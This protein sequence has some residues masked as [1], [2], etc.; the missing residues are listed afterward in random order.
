MRP[1]YAHATASSR[2]VIR[3]FAIY[4]LN[5]T[6]KARS[7][8]TCNTAE[9]R[10]GDALGIAHRCLSKK[11]RDGI[12]GSCEEAPP[13]IDSASA[14]MQWKRNHY[15]KIEEKFQQQP[16]SDAA[17]PSFPA[18]PTDGDNPLPIER[19]EDV[20]L[21][22]K[23]MESRVTKRKSRTLDELAQKGIVSGRRNVRRSD[24]DLWLAAG[25]YDEDK[26]KHKNE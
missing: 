11:G 16:E 18:W 6:F 12:I 8:F 5:N 9:L 10:H 3:Q 14:T 22:W 2:Q 20:Q 13:I 15:R 17:K 25:V 4:Q 1:A 7:F 19:D 26:D 21:M 23:G 24:E